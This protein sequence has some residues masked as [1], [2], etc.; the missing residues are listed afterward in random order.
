MRLLKISTDFSIVPGARYYSD[1]PLSGEEFYDN[2]LRKAFQEA[3]ENNE[4]LT[5]DLDGTAGYASSFLSESFG[6]LS[7]HFG[8]DIVLKNIEI[9]S[10][11]EPDWK[12][13]ILENYIPNAPKRKKKPVA[14]AEN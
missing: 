6:L 4:K 7:E 3:L 13:A 8:K 12:I 2:N 5:V 11:L 10:V 14:N 1:G 9:I